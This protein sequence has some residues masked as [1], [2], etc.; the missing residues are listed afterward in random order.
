MTKLSDLIDKKTLKQINES[1]L[2][3]LPS[4]KLMKMKWNPVTGKRSQVKEDKLNESHG[5]VEIMDMSMKSETGKDIKRT[6]EPFL[7]IWSIWKGG[8]ATETSMHRAAKKDL[9]DY[10]TWYL[11]KKNQINKSR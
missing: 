2:G 6:L 7:K 4:K 9:I 8:P 3:D 1:V 5:Y 10:V 11:D